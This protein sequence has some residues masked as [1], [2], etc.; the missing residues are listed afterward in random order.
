MTIPSDGILIGTL[1]A[2]DVLRDGRYEIERLLRSAGDKQ[3]YLARDRTLG[4]QVTI[5]VFSNNSIMRL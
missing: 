1:Q 3:V 2:G 5:D 4:C